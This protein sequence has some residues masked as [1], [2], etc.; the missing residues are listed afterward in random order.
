MVRIYKVWLTKTVNEAY[1]V[2]AT[3]ELT[4]MEIARGF[5]EDWPEDAVEAELVDIEVD[6]AEEIEGA[7]GQ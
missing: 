3:N 4:A 6:N 2:A 7:E 5:A 1:F